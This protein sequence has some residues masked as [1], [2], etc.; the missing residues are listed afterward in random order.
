MASKTTNQ[1]SPI[2]DIS[3]FYQN[4]NHLKIYTNIK[5]TIFVVQMPCVTSCAKGERTIL[6]QCY[7]EISVKRCVIEDCGH[8]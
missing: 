3:T 7:F 1:G 6:L 2:L 4:L 5:Q 8:L